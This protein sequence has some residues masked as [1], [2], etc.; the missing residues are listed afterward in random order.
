MVIKLSATRK[1]FYSTH[2]FLQVAHAHSLLGNEYVLIN[3]TRCVCL[4]TFHII[5][6]CTRATT[7]VRD[8]VSQIDWRARVSVVMC[9]RV[10]FLFVFNRPIATDRTP[11]VLTMSKWLALFGQSS[12]SD[13]VSL[14]KRDLRI[15]VL[16]VNG[17]DEPPP[18][19]QA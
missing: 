17:E 4:Q 15:Y 7:P 12:G 19:T 8:G 11:R 18:P 5:K 2:Y 3:R 14:E 6:L 10:L 1:M 16:N 9:V 13:F